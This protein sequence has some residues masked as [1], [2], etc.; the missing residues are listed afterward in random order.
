MMIGA[1]AFFMRNLPLLLTALFLG[2]LQSTLFGPV[3]YAILPQHLKETELIGGNA[4]VEGGTSVAVL[5]GMIYGG[6]LIAFG[7]WGLVAVAASTC[8]VSAIAL[9][10][11][12]FVPRAPPADP[13]LRINWNPVTETWRNLAHLTERRVVFLSILGISWFW[14]YGAI[15]VT[16]FPNLSRNVLSGT[17]YVV[18][19]LL[20]VFSVGVAVGSLLCERLSGHK[21]EIGLV[22]FGSIGMTL[23]GIDLW[24]A[25][26]GIAPQAPLGAFDFLRDSAH[27]RILVDLA[28]I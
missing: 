11:S 22:P 2:G 16:Q 5:L 9:A 20:V 24:W 25:T 7:A 13:G 23:F 8:T 21:I 28:C 14:F 27:W 18:T 4:L 10:I 26:S 3:K 17:E 6:S 12:R 15:L 19:V 1:A